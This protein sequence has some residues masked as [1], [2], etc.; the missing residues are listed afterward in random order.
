MSW[1][2]PLKNYQYSIPEGDHPG[3]FLKERKHHFHEGIDLYGKDGQEVYSV[4]NGTVHKI[5]NFTGEKANS[6]WWNNTDAII[7]KGSSGF[8]L[9]G[10]IKVNSKIKEGDFISQGQFIGKITPVLKKRKNNPIAMLHFEWY[11]KE[12]N[13]PV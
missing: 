12:V 9:Y 8:V 11:S 3:S 6:P 13:D 4:E 5:L 10:E 7:I 1:L 2:F